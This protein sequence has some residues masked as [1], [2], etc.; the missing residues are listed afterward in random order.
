M[1][2]RFAASVIAALVVALALTLHIEEGR[3][4][5]EQAHAAAAALATTN[6]AAERDSTRDLAQG[7]G[8]VARLLG[9]SL[10]LV[11][12]HVRQIAQRRDALD[13]A[14][15]TERLARYTLTATVDSLRRTVTSAA[16]RDSSA[17][18]SHATWQASFDIRQ[19]PYTIAAVVQF[20]PPPDS[21]RLDMR[22][23]IDSIPVEAR[24]AC[25]SP[26]ESGIKT[27]SITATSPPWARLRFDRV[28]QSPDLCASPALA[29][30]RKASRLLA[31]TPLVLGG[32]R[33][34]ASNGSGTWGLFVGTGLR[35][36]D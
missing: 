10:R 6:L 30:P 19:E 28:E 25:A 32:G 21:A 11:E 7:N 4:S 9:D 16:T 26:N 1:T 31:F 13:A 17:G 2:F 12:K 35:L 3:V 8:A 36:W 27:A 20:P 14:I 5:A 33:V 18:A 15:G 23:A 22:V 29:H 24:I 34:L